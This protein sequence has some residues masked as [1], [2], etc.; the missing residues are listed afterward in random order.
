MNYD[1][2]ALALKKQRL[3]LESAAQR[4][5]WIAHAQGLLPVCNGVD[6]VGDGVRWLRT[7][8]QALAAIGVATSVALM[9]ARPRS[10]LR[11]ARRSFFAWQTWRR[12]TAW[13]AKQ[14]PT[15]NVFGMKQP[16]E[17]KS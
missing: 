6:R 1:E 7:H 17:A 12:G 15:Q 5:R 13:L 4:E 8:P 10:M 2:L 16:G 11:W 9:V 3:Q 14:G